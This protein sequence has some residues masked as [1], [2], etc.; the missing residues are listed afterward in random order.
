MNTEERK[1][2][3]E[4]EKSEQSGFGLRRA[5][6]CLGKMFVIGA[7]DGGAQGVPRN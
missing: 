5:L 3:G 2:G 6:A 7:E 1:G 4:L